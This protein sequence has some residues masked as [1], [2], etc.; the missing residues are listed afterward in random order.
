MNDDELP[1]PKEDINCPISRLLKGI[2][3]AEG[4]LPIAALSETVK[5]TIR[6]R[7]KSKK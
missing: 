5:K 3:G 2:K 1:S 6:K 7:K 4:W